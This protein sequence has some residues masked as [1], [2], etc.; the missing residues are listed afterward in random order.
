MNRARVLFFSILATT[1]GLAQACGGD[2]SAPIAASDAGDEGAQPDATDSDAGGDVGAD[3]SLGDAGADTSLGDAADAAD[4]TDAL[5]ANETS[6]TLDGAVCDGGAVAVGRVDPAFATAAAATPIAIT[7]TGFVLGATVFLRSSAQQLTAL[8]QVAFVSDT[9]LSASVPAGLAVGTYDVV[10][11]DPNGC[12]GFFGNF[13]VS[14]NAAPQVLSVSPSQATTQQTSVAVTIT[15]CHLPASPTLAMVTSTNAVIP[16]TAGAATC[17]VDGGG[18]TCSDGSP[19][20]TMTGTINASTLA[21]GAFLVRV[22]NTTD[23]TYGDYATFVVVSPDGHLVGSWAAGPALNVGRRSLGLVSGRIN[24][25]NLFL[26]AVGGE[27]AAGVALDSVEVAALGRFGASGSWTLQ[28][29]H[30]NTP[31]SGLA[32]VR[33]GRYLYALGGTAGTNGTHGIMPTG[34]ALASIERAVILDPS[35]A[36]AGVAATP[37]SGGTLAAGTYY[38]KVAAV[39]NGTGEN[40]NGESLASDELVVTV[41]SSGQVSLTWTAV[42]GADHYLVYRSPTAT[43]TAQTEVLLAGNVAS[44]SFVDNGSSDAGAAPQKPLAP[45]SLGVWVTQSTALAA[46]RLDTAAAIA[47][48]QAGN[49]RVYVVGGWGDCPGE[50]G[51]GSSRVMDCAESAVLNGTGDAFTSAFAVDASHKLNHARMR[52]G[53]SSLT[54]ANGPLNFTSDAGADGG[55]NNAA[56]LVVA[57]GG[58]DIAQASG[59]TVEYELV[60]GGTPGPWTAATNDFSVARDGTQMQIANGYAYA[61]FGGSV[62]AVNV[63]YRSTSDISTKLVVGPNTIGFGPWQN[64][65]GN[66]GPTVGRH[67]VALESA[68]FYVVGGTSDDND[69]LNTVYSIIY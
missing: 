3:T 21:A 41:A 39:M 6:T 24:D 4:A 10:V 34:A 51:T 54:A 12:A 63:G 60:G 36:P 47:P 30:L 17:G 42:A 40:P 52:H 23:G 28:R 16:E 48:D 13:K 22:G 38:Y 15:G 25:A 53:L 57:G 27:N 67:G 5:D 64:A 20:C 46:A 29:N 14:A 58:V 19:V 33:Q 65:N 45:G 66:G 37:S 8:N 50:A 31:R 44:T 32:L 2:D 7:G 62:S 59:P 1:V 49:L 61:F 18:L 56:F 26:Y 11:V 9:S 69:A 55:P 35:G 43:S 68:F